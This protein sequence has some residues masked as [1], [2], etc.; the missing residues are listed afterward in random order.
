MNEWLVLGLFITSTTLL[1][2]SVRE[3][4][5][6]YFRINILEDKLDYMHKMLERIE[7]QLESEIEIEMGPSDEPKQKHSLFLLKERTETNPP[8]LIQ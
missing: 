8:I 2:W 5:R 3:L 7:E 4:V 1:L 6:W